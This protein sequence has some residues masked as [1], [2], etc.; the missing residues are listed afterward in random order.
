MPRSTSLLKVAF[1]LSYLKLKLDLI[2]TQIALNTKANF[3]PDQ[4]RDE[5]GRWCGSNNGTVQV[6]RRDRTGNPKID[7]K[8]DLLIDVLREVVNETASDS[9]PLY[10][11]YI[12]SLAEKRIIELDIPGIGK[13]GV[14]QSF[15]AGDLVRYGLDGSIRTDVILRE[16]RGTN[17]RILAIWDIKTGNARLTSTRA[18]E[19]RINSGVDASVPIIEIHVIRGINVKQIIS[20]L[21]QQFAP[22]TPRR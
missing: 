22:E 20:T 10:G 4:L 8:T 17:G 2:R 1:E 15:S 11:V 14:E 19:L 9:G 3:D 16:G 6:V 18:E 13:D 5:C 21:Y 7:A 12:H